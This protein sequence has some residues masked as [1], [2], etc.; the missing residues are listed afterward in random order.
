[1]KLSGYQVIGLNWLV[2][3]HKQGLN[4]VLADEMGLGK[5]IQAISFLAYLLEAG[6]QGPHL[7]VVPSSTLDNWEREIRKWIPSVELLVY[8]GSQVSKFR[9]PVLKSNEFCFEYYIVFLSFSCL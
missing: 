3:M 2:L 1:M 6:H 7:I 4:G 5:T 9:N 8:H